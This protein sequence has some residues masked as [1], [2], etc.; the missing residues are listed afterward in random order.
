MSTTQIRRALD[1][2]LDTHTAV[3]MARIGDVRELLCTAETL[4]AHLPWGSDF[5]TALLDRCNAARARWGL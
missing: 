2:L 5:S 3:D 1:T 4:A